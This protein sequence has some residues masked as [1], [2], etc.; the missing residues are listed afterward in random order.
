MTVFSIFVPLF[1]IWR[2]PQY[3]GP[4]GFILSV[5]YSVFMLLQ[6]VSLK[7]YQYPKASML[8][9]STPY[10]RKLLVL[11]KY[12]FCLAIFAACCIIFWVETLIFPN[13]GGF[14]YEMATLTFFV[15][16]VFLGVYLPIQYKL[17]YEKT[18]F[19]FFIIIMASPFLL[20]W[21]FAMDSGVD[22]NFLSALPPLP[23]YSGIFLM[24]LAILT[25]SACISI[26]IYGKADLS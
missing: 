2:V 21:L 25:I 15:L 9:C 6:Y 13:L 14:H 1:L 3:G 22:M 19:A 11:S 10:P 17:G 5:I 4:M 26:I 12:I 8:L 7:E 16:T 18:R 23:L 24:S 20:P